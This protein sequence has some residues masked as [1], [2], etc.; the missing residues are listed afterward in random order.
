MH[1]SKKVQ[2]CCLLYIVALL[3]V[4]AMTKYFTATYVDLLT[5]FMPS[6]P[7]GGIGIFENLFGINFS[8]NFVQNRGSA[9]GLFA[10]H[11]NWLLAL[12][13]LMV[14]GLAYYGIF[15]LKSDRFALPYTMIL[16]GAIGNI[17]DCFV[18]GYVVDMFHFVFFGWHYPVFNVADS[19]ICI[20]VGLFLIYSIRD[21]FAQRKMGAY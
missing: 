18:Y 14:M 5:W 7:Y 12:R 17:I 4:D 2:I 9:W 3:A 20:G 16:A 13:V 11:H 15:K 10:D 8:I 6:Y 19:S 21:H 1:L